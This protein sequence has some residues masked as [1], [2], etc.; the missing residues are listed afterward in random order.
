MGNPMRKEFV[1]LVVTALMIVPGLASADIADSLS[2]TIGIGTVVINS[3][4]NLNPDGSKKRLNNLDSGA[5]RETALRPLILPRVTWDVGEPEGIKY[6]LT[7]DPPIDEVGGFAF[8]LGASYEVGKAGILDTGVFFTPFEKAWK[9][10]YITGVDREETDTTKYGFRVGLNRIMGT[11]F[12]AQLVYLNDDVDDDDIG[13]V[14]P[15]LA[16]DG[17]V[18]SLNLNYSYYIGKNLE[19]R[20]RVSI[21]NGDYDG[22]ANSFMKYKIDFEAR[23]KTGQWMIIPRVSFSHSDFEETNPIFDKTRKNDSYGANLMA[24]YMAPFN[25]EKWS[26]TCLLALSKG[27]SNIDFYDTE[28]MTLGMMLSYH[29]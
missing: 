19:L 29:F 15:E 3:G 1:S 17:A 27:D 25:W 6:Y 26:A 12:R 8:H 22:E 7:T 21:R 11:G 5:D 18:Y 28:A 24:T 4:N 23:Y 9:N 16:R 10:P 13:G 20:P 14:M 2:G